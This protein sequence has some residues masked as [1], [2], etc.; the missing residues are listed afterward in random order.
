[1]RYLFFITLLFLF[2]GFGHAQSFHSEIGVEIQAASFSNQGGT[3]GGG[4]KY[5]I[6]EEETIAFGPSLRY[7]YFFSQNTYLGTSGSSF[8]MGGGGF[9]HYRFLEWFFLG[10]EIELLKNPF[11]YIYPDKKWTLTAFIGGGVSKDLGPVRLNIGILYDLVD[12]LNDPYYSNPSPLS[13]DYFLR[14]NNP[15]N[16]NAGKYI[17]LIYR[18]AFFFSLNRK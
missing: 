18:V 9:F 7:Q 6:V 12:G 5:T 13:R 8:T 15:N 17:P 3:F 4:L 10:T 2:T 11:N 14:I 1:M 16:P